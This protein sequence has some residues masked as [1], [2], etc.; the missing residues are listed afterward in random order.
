MSA[1]A[2][3]QLDNPAPIVGDDALLAA[4]LAALRLTQ[5]TIADWLETAGD[6]GWFRTHGLDGC[7]TAARKTDAGIEW[8]DRTPIPVTRARA[9]LRG[10]AAGDRNYALATPG[11]GAEIDLL[12]SRFAA[13]QALFVIA[14]DPSRLRAVL[15]LR[16]H[17]IDIRRSRLLF[18]QAPRIQDELLSMLRT[19][20]GLLV[21]AALLATP[22]TD[23]D[24]TGRVTSALQ[25][26]AAQISAERATA[27][28]ALRISPS[29]PARTTRVA[30]LALQPDS[31]DHALAL[32][33]TEELSHAGIAATLAALDGPLH[34]HS[35]VHERAI[36]AFA[37]TIALAINHPP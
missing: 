33:L 6:A 26:V 25:H 34:A 19:H 9:T 36:A 24:W 3:A 28:N 12:L 13:H 14:D 32:R 15:S 8:L 1:I 30:V 2:V 16:D 20:E 5:P 21:P 11:S 37:P 35:L 7:L 10:V 18:V 31:I 27:A 4:N 23:A 22:P 17:A 29:A